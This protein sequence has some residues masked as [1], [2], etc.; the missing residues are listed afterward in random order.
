[1]I[2]NRGDDSEHQHL[3]YIKQLNAALS[4]RPPEMA[5][6]THSCRG[7]FQSHWVTEGGY[8]FVAEALFNELDVD[9]FLLE[10]DDQRS[11]NFEPLRFVPPG[12]M[13]VLGLVTTKRGKLESKDELKREDRR[14]QP[15][16]GPGAALPVTAVW[17]L[18]DRGGEPA[19][20]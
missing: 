20:P 15:V 14:G 13:V 10:Y 16:R 11:G 4:A 19:H 18:I 6:T 2:A 9:G 7:N 8:D 17:F 5:V 1:M 3:R 12:K